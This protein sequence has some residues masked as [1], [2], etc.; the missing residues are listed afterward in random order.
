MTA[1]ADLAY[2]LGRLGARLGARAGAA[3]WRALDSRRT[4]AHALAAAR[5]GPLAGWV[6]GLGS[7]GDPAAVERHL[8][9]AWQMQ[10]AAVAAWMPARWGAALRLFGTL[11]EPPPDDDP[12]MLGWAEAWARALPPDARPGIPWRRPAEVLRP[13]LTG[14][15]IGRPAAAPAAQAALLRLYR[16]HAGNA[17]PAF[18]YLGLA[19]LDLERL[20]GALVA[21]A[22][23]EAE[24]EP[25]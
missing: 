7:A 17:L 3:A 19:A 12:G 21:R 16:R 8:Q 13:R 25:A 20:R 9:A 15:L 5:S 10:V 18:A 4:A 14:D 11:A 23:F 22:M 1:H 6:D 2:A 24:A